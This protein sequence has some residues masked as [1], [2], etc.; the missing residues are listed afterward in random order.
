MPPR[1]GFLLTL[2]AAG[3]AG[4]AALARPL[5]RIAPARLA[6]GYLVTVTALTGVRVVA[7]VAANAFGVNA[8]RPAGTG[9]R[10]LTNLLV[11]GLYGL[12]AVHVRGGGFEGF[13]R[14]PDVR[15]ALRIATGVAFILA[16]LGN[17]FFMN[18]TGIDYFVQVGY[19]KN[20][21]LFIVAAEVLG[22]AALLL[23]WRWL[24]LTAAA[25]LTID[26]FGA[27]Y[28]QLKAG[29]PVDDTAAAIAMLL[30]LAPLVLLCLDNRWVLAAAGA[31]G[32]GVVAIVG[33]NLLRRPGPAS[34]SR[35]GE[36]RPAEVVISARTRLAIERASSSGEA[37]DF[38]PPRSSS[39]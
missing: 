35:G 23:P 36:S 29:D 28:T 38:G 26:M 5:E 17:V 3:A 24:I 39:V 20:F 11:G 1:I 30:R 22:G 37:V 15:L 2:I 31:V 32:C 7:W 8:L 12:A 14:S 9:P 34:S 13:L 10:D 21:H 27:V 16:G 25:G 4:G 18:A 19:T 6:R 33:A